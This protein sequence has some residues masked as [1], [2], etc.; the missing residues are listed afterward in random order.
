MRR[1]L[2]NLPLT[3]L[4]WSMI[5]AAATSLA[6]PVATSDN[7]SSAVSAEDKNEPGSD[8]HQRMLKLLREIAEQTGGHVLSPD[9]AGAIHEYVPDRKYVIPDDLTETIWDSK[10]ALALFVILVTGEWIMR[11]LSGLT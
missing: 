3:L 4:L 1:F 10:L 9:K 6:Q 7:A 11:K 5:W 2:E 8:G